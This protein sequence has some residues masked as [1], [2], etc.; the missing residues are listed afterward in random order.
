MAGKAKGN[1]HTEAFIDA[2]RREQCLWD[3]TSHHYKN[4]EKKQN[5]INIIMEKFDMTG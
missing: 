5:S 4:R 2:W 3:L 1:E